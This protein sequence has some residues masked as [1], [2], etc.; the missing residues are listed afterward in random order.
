ME[1]P[2]FR[3]FDQ[4]QDVKFNQKF[5]SQK[6]FENSFVVSK[7]FTSANNIE[8]DTTSALSNFSEFHVEVTTLLETNSSQ[9]LLSYAR[10]EYEED[11]EDAKGDKAFYYSLSNLISDDNIIKFNDGNNAGDV[12]EVD[13]FVVA[14][15]FKKDRINP[16]NFVVFI[17]TEDQNNESTTIT[18]FSSGENIAGLYP[19]SKKFN[20]KIGE[21]R[22]LYQINTSAELYNPTTDELYPFDDS[23]L[24]LSDKPLG[25]V[26]LDSGLVILFIDNIKEKFTNIVTEDVLNYFAGIGGLSQLQINI[27]S[28]FM[29][30]LNNEFNYTTNP[31]FYEDIEDNVILET[32]REFPR[33]F[34]TKVGLFNN[35]GEQIAVGTLSSPFMKTE[36]NELSLR[37]DL[38]GY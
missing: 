11:Y 10:A 21:K 36:E 17:H 1:T 31:T 14:R 5:V 33:T 6:L 34:I 32:F 29:R 9:P 26:Y 35:Q 4:E 23:K 2:A 27:Q 25:A 18:E 8:I 16:N 38:V 24:K 3:E 15:N 12:D 19:S 20:S 37:A 28:F 22:Y 13:A 30:A 7:P